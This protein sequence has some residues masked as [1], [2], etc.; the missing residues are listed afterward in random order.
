MPIDL[1]HSMAVDPILLRRENGGWLA[2]APTGAPFRIAVAAW[3][4]DDAR[5]RFEREMR[6]WA[7]IAEDGVR[8]NS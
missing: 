5:H 2:V 3:S 1:Q 8:Q 4:A 7:E 6:E